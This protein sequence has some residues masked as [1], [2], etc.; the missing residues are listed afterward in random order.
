M[1]TS[2]TSVCADVL[3][4]GIDY[5]YIS[6]R[7]GPQNSVSATLNKNIE[8]AGEL[9]STHDEE[10]MRLILR[11][12]CAYYFPPCGN[13]THPHPPSSIC[14]EECVFVQERCPATWQAAALA[15][16]NLEPFLSCKRPSQLLHPLP[17]C[18]TGAGIQSHK[19]KPY[20]RDCPLDTQVF[21]LS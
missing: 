21:S 20:C 11:L 1:Y 17:N 16:K 18:C 6:S 19:S 15:M 14:H 7:L 9:L 10:C 3:R 8:N 12:I 5:I 13:A 4:L 2:V